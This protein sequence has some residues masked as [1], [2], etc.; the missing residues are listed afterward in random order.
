MKK[1]T[2]VLAGA[3]ALA[4]F[5][6]LPAEAQ[7]R[8]QKFRLGFQTNLNTVQGQGVQKFADAI[9]TKSGGKMKMDVFPGGTLGGDLQTIAAIRGGTVDASVLAT[10]TLVGLVKEYGLFDLPFL[11]QNH[12]EAAAVI[13]GPF[14][15]RLTGLLAEKGVISFGYW[16]VGFRNLT[17]SRRP[18]A[19]LDDVKGLKIRV[20]QNP[21][22]VDLWS[23]LGANAV[24][25][26]FPEVY[27]ALEQKAIDGQE[28]P[29]ATIVSNKLFEVQ[30]Y[31]SHTKHIY[32]VATLIFGKPTWD[33]LN[34]EERKVIEAAALE[35][36]NDW[37]RPKAIQED[38]ELNEE[39]KKSLSV[40][41][42]SPAELEKFR[43]ATKSVVD[44][45]AAAADPVVVKELFDSVA[46]AR[47]K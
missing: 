25:M 6:A 35:T 18:V 14:G 42:I 23:A 19:T 33:R 29:A 34:D 39:L 45:H 46:K 21:V 27:T 38:G 41:E 31:Y 16:G 24:P 2:T 32:F 30:K 47:G 7:I 4:G 9:A 17:N 36:R 12:E 8:E 28:N 15:K 11:F 20:L 13:D 5:L 1:I 44:K 22:Y 37:W 40:S 26:P 10:S 3:L 43:A